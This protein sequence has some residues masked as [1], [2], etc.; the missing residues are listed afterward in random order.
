[1]I[2]RLNQSR[3]Q[4]RGHLSELHAY[5]RQSQE[6]LQ[7]LR[8]QIQA[9]TDRLRQQELALHRA[10]SEHRLAVTAF[11]QQIIDWQGRVGEMKHLFAQ[12]ET[13]L[14]LKQQA[15][16]AVAKEVDESSQKL[17]KQS[18]TLQQQ[19]REVAD[20]QNRGRTPPR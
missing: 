16:A 19:Q 8:A 11:R 14:D 13:R 9:E 6:D 7:E 1:M 10:R 2:E 15:L 18:E 20:A 4:L 5:A 17:A 3:E 12:N